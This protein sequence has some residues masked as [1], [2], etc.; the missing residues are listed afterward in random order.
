MNIDIGPPK[1][2]GP[3]MQDAKCFFSEICD[4]SKVFSLGMHLCKYFVLICICA[5]IVIWDYNVM[6]K[7]AKGQLGLCSTHLCKN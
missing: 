2:G 1:G 7:Y 3:D 6:C 5:K 4:M